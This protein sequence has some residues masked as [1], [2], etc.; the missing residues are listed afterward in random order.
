MAPNLKLEV[1]GKMSFGTDMGQQ[2]RNVA[3]LGLFGADVATKIRSDGSHCLLIF[4]CQNRQERH[5]VE[6]QR[7][8]QEETLVE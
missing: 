1:V 5:R 4:F 6:K 2:V 3:E 8:D 7:N